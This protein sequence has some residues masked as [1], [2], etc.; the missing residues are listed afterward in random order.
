M[1]FEKHTFTESDFWNFIDSCR[2]TLATIPLE[3][4]ETA[5]WDTFRAAISTLSPEELYYFDD[6]HT[7][8]YVQ[9]Y[10]RE[11]WCAIG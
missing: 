10:R 11:I 9:L 2:A 7:K 4:N 3:A 8:N 6:V 5:I 1:R